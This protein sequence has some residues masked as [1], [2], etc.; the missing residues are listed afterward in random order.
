[1][2]VLEMYLIPRGMR[3][4]GEHQLLRMSVAK[5]HGAKGEAVHRYTVSFPEQPEAFKG[6]ITK[7]RSGHRNPLHLLKDIVT[8]IDLRTLGKD[9]VTTVFDPP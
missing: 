6:T 9:Y 4:L 8:A 3:I 7:T 1:M 5:E 2:V